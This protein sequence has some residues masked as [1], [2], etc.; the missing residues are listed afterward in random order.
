MS[1]IIKSYKQFSFLFHQR[2]DSNFLGKEVEV[3]ET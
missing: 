1:E 2:A 3:L